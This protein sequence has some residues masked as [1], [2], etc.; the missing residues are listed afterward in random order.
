MQNRE[1]CEREREKK[2]TTV[3]TCSEHAQTKNNIQLINNIILVNKC[4]TQCVTIIITS[5]HGIPS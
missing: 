5:L 3:H 1:Q 2:D 4:Y